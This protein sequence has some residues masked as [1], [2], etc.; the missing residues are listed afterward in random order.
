MQQQPMPAPVLDRSDDATV[1]ADASAAWCWT[2]QRLACTTPSLPEWPQ[3]LVHLLKDDDDESDE[4]G[5]APLAPSPRGPSYA[6]IERVAR[7]YEV[8][9]RTARLMFRRARPWPV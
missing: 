6:A 3:G 5:F 2:V 7:I 9:E 1:P 4:E 8:S